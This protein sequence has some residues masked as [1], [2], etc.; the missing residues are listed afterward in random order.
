[1]DKDT[2]SRCET[3]VELV[4]YNIPPLDIPS[5]VLKNIN[6]S[7]FEANGNYTWSTLEELQRDMCIGYLKSMPLWKRLLCAARLKRLK[8][9]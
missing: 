8:G 2:L 4:H 1:M 6:G 9:E 5:F 7:A 3:M